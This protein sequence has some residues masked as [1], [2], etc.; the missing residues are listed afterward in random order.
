MADERSHLIQKVQDS[1]TRKTSSSLS[2]INQYAGVI[3]VLLWA[4]INTIAIT[5][6]LF[7]PS[8]STVSGW[9]NTLFISAF[10]FFP[11]FGYLGEK[12]TRYKV[13]ITGIIILVV[14]YTINLIL[15]TILV[16]L[17]EASDIIEYL[18]II[19]ILSALV[20]FGLFLS[21]IIQF[22]TDQLQ[23]APSQHLAA[24]VRW[25]VCIFAFCWDL[26]IILQLVATTFE[27]HLLYH[28]IYCFIFILLFGFT[29]TLVC[30]CKQRLVI[31]PPTHID[32]VKMIWRVMKYAW[33]HKYPV[34][35]SA[36]TYNEN[37]PSRLDLAKERYGGPF[38]TEQVEDVKSFWNILTILLALVGNS[39]I[40]TRGVGQQYIDAM[41]INT[42]TITFFEN[43][44]LRFP[45]TFEYSIV[46]LYIPI[47]V[48]VPFFPYYVPKMLKRMWIG[49]VFIL[50]SG[51][52]LTV[53][54]A[55]LNN[56]IQEL[57]HTS[58]CGEH[59]QTS[60]ITISNSLWPYYVLIIPQLL[61]GVGFL[62]NLV[63]ILEFI[64]AQGPHYMQGTLI[65]TL[66]LKIAVT[67][68]I[69]IV[70]ESTSAGCYWEKYAAICGFVFISLIIYSIAAY[71]YKYRQRNELADINVRVNIEEIYERRLEK[72]AREQD[73]DDNISCYSQHNYLSEVIKST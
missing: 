56:S 21:N 33:K 43:I 47:L 70:G 69:F 68:L 14:S 35:R 46:F 39:T 71:R 34:R 15:T 17:D 58:F 51:I 6:L 29:I 61:N 25:F 36:F 11:I 22:G 73:E 30:C 7:Y 1:K 37:P 66:F 63:T 10:V 20:G 19:T 16:I 53:I 54:S 67:L 44:I 41:G 64:L 4:G 38:T 23:F 55:A 32:P 57:N 24:F 12:W 9:D 72:E 26:N 62:L 5:L 8:L 40:D 13:I 50:F 52:T 2:C 48:V 3:L 65:G 18:C 42:T 60:N 45:E 49:L 31:E 27:F 28:G 59:Y